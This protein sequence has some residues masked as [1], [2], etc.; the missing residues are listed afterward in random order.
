[1]SGRCHLFCAPCPAINCFP[2]K[3]LELKVFN[4]FFSP[5]SLWLSHSFGCY[6][7]LDPSDWVE[8]ASVWGTSLLGVAIR[9]VIC[10]ICLFI[11]LFIYFSAWLCCPPRFQD[12]PQTCRWEGFL[13]FGNLPS[14]KTPF[15]G[16]IS[17]PNSF[18]SLFIFYILSYLPSKTMGCF[19]GCL[20]SSA[21][22]QKL[23]CGIFSV[24]KC[25]FD[26]FVEEKVVSP[27][28]SSAILGPTPPRKY[29][30]WGLPCWL[31]GKESANQCRIHV[32]NLWSGKIP[33]ASEQLSPCATT[34]EPVFQSL[35]AA[36]TKAHMP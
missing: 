28:Y 25:C 2:L 15:L 13:V 18:V 27:S 8:D 6:L 31:C 20:M 32:S 4:L 17:I 30:T 19:S 9:H 29:S 26:E 21:R 35:G 23:F 7:T 14:F 22:V 36:N 34:T 1:M 3:S 24:F 33:H 16:R 10:G 5:L 11:Y 12:S